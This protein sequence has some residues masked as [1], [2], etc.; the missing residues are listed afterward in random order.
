MQ[1][2]FTLQ[3]LFVS[4]HLFIFGGVAELVNAAEKQAFFVKKTTALI[5]K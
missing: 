4:Q 1:R 3:R 2:L 5:F